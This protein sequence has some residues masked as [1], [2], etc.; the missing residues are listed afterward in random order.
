MLV[1]PSIFN[2]WLLSYTSPTARI[3]GAWC[4]II[5]RHKTR[6]GRMY[7]NHEKRREGGVWRPRAACCVPITRYLYTGTAVTAA[8]LIMTPGKK[9]HTRTRTIRVDWSFEV[10]G[11]IYAHTGILRMPTLNV[12]SC[13]CCR[14]IMIGISL[15]AT[16][17]SSHGQGALSRWLWICWGLWSYN[18]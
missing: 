11:N 18:W 1:L 3:V 9:K 8:L 17:V 15:D 7:A 2:S 4:V 14:L 5:T 12:C 16:A 10:T 6:F 13:Y